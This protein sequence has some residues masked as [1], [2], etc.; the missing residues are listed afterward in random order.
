MADVKKKE[1]QTAFST[2][3]K[4]TLYAPQSMPKKGQVLQHEPGE[5]I[6]IHP[7]L[8]PKFMGFGY[9]K[10]APAKA[11]ATAETPASGTAGTMTNGGVK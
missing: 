8:V 9:T 7:N 3:E 1:V 5:K 4:E 10:E 11:A 6:E 2:T